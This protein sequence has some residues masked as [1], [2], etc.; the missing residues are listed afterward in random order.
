MAGIRSAVLV[1]PEISDSMQHIIINEQR[2]GFNR[3]YLISSLGWVGSLGAVPHDL[4]G[5]LALE[6]RQNLLHT[7]D[8]LLKRLLD[9]VLSLVVFFLHFPLIVFIGL[10]VRLDSRGPLFYRHNRIGKDGKMIA[11]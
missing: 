8:R 5:V 7:S 9:I 1:L 3:L 6:L 11:C 10:W 2:L 4:E